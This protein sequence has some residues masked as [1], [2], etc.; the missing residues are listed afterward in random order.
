MSRPMRYTLKHVLLLWLAALFPAGII[1][2]QDA[3]PPA[4]GPAVAEPSVPSETEQAAAAPAP[5]TAQPTVPMAVIDWRGSIMFSS[6]EM[7]SLRAVYESFVHRSQNPEEAE[8]QE[9]DFLSDLLDSAPQDPQQRKIPV[10]YLSSVAYLRPGYWMVWVNDK[11]LEPVQPSTDDGLTVEMV[12]NNAVLFS[13]KPPSLMQAQQALEKINQEG[14]AGHAN[15][16]RSYVVVDREKAQ[17]RFMLKPNQ[18]FNGDTME[19]LE[20][21]VMPVTSVVSIGPPGEQGVMPAP[22][23]PASA[24]SP[25]PSSSA[26]TT[27]LT[28]PV[29]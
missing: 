10:F 26:T 20:G 17:V 25:P 8:T 2:A 12:K 21:R 1:I 29:P 3:P 19:V 6:Q 23:D 7:A 15:R 16:T 4:S 18:T 27:P 28:A 24:V 9:D 11:K 22:I 5:A 13:W 14:T